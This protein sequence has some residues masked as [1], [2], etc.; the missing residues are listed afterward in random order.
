VNEFLKLITPSG[1]AAACLAIVI[2][3]LLML[4]IFGQF[5]G[6]AGERGAQGEKGQQG[7]RGERG[8]RGAKGD[9]GPHWIIRFVDG[10]CRAPCT[11]SCEA[12]E[13]ILTVHGINPG[14]SLVFEDDGRVTF[15]PQGRGTSVRVVVACAPK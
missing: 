11:I 4:S 14:G 15:R 9:S 6:P 7:E 10:E 5:N 13:R 8:E 3:A 1:I 12:N 2:F